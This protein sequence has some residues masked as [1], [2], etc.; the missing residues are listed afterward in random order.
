MGNEHSKNRDLNKNGK[1][2]GK[3]ENGSANRMST[4]ITTNGVEVAVNGGTMAKQ[5]SESLSLNHAIES[6]DFIIIE[7]DSKPTEAPVISEINETII[8]KKEVKEN[9]EDQ[10]DET[11][12]PKQETESLTWPE[13]VTLSPDEVPETDSQP[14]ED[15]EDGTAEENSVMNFFKTLVTST[16]TKKETPAAKDQSQKENQPAAT[17]TVSKSHIKSFNWLLFPKKE[18]IYRT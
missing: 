14:A 12:K 10:T 5:N 4:N 7:Q 3:H 17:T 9:K 11:T 8:Q 13:S 1:V 18:Y 6:T 15:Q 16:K 2:H